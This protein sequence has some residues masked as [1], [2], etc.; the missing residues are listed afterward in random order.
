MAT[1]IP[2]AAMTLKQVLWKCGFMM[3]VCCFRLCCNSDIPVVKLY[4]H[5]VLLVLYV[6]V[7]GNLHVVLR[8]RSRGPPPHVSSHYRGAYF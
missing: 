5:I 4:I 7:S 3:W 6:L 1:K 2:T 8:P